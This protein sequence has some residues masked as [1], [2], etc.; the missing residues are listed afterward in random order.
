MPRVPQNS[1]SEDSTTPTTAPQEEV[2]GLVNVK[3]IL[4]AFFPMILEQ[5]KVIFSFSAKM[6]IGCIAS[7]IKTEVGW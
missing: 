6:V 5:S 2:P 4:F 1:V 7:F 3:L